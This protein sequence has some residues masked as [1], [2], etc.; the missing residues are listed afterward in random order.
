[1][2]RCHGNSVVIKRAGYL[3]RPH[4]CW[5]IPPLTPYDNLSQLRQNLLKKYV[6][7]FLQFQ[8]IFKFQYVTIFILWYENCFNFMQVG[9]VQIG[10]YTNK[11]MKKQRLPLLPV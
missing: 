5:L 1:M 3:T 2:R 9:A 4:F 8:I 11:K 6:I 10:I 7:W